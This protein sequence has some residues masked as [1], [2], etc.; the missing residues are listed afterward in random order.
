MKKYISD[1]YMEYDID[2]HRYILTNEAMEEFYGIDL[3][4]VLNAEGDFNPDTLPYRF[5]DRVSKQ[6]YNYIYSWAADKNQTEFV[7][8]DK[9]YRQDIQDAML[10]LAYSYL[11]ENKDPNILFKESSLGTIVVPPVVQTILMNGG[12]L[13]R[14]QFNGLPSD[15]LDSKGIDY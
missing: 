13:F 12:L 14:G 3:R 2:K 6:V 10:E 11:M 9:S 15:Y 7:I 8:S 4:A 5:L 1:E